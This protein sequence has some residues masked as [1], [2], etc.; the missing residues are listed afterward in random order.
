MTTWK[1]LIYSGSSAELLHVTASQILSEHLHL[2]TPDNLTT[3]FLGLKIH[4]NDT[5]ATKTAGMSFVISTNSY[6]ENARIHAQRLHGVASGELVF[7]TRVNQFNSIIE[8]MRINASGSVGIG[9]N[10]PSEL[11]TVAGNVSASGNLQIDGTSTF[12]NDVTLVSSSVNI[13]TFDEGILFYNGSNYTSNRIKLTTAQNLQYLAGGAHQFNAQSVQ[14]LS[15]T[16]LILENVDNTD[17]IRLRNNVGSGIGKARLDFTD[18]SN[19]VKMSISSS[20]KVGIGTTSPGN[21][22]HVFSGSMQVENGITGHLYLH[23]SNNYVYGDVNGVGI[24][25]AND[26]LRLSTAGNERIRVD[27]MGK[28]GIG[29]ST[30]TATLEVNGNIKATSFTGSL[31]GTASHAVSS[32]TASYALNAGDSIWHDSTTFISSSVDV[33]ISGSLNV[34]GDTN[35]GGDLGIGGSIFS[36]TGFGI[37]IDDVAVTSGSVNFGSGSI[38]SETNHSFT[39]SVSITGS[40]LILNDGHLNVRGTST[41]GWSNLSNARI[42]AGTSGQGI[43]IDTN[44]IAQ[45]GDH[46][47]IGTISSK[48]LVFRTNGANTRLTIKADGKVGIGTDSPNQKFEVKSGNIN[49]QNGDGGFLSFNNGDAN[50]KIHYND[51]QDGDTLITGRDLAFETFKTG[52]GTTEK[53]R[54]T[55]DGDVG[56]GT[57]TPTEKLHVD[58]NVRV[59]STQGYY[60]SFLQAIS[61]T[62]L[63]I[64]NDDYS[65]Y[66]FFKDDGNVGIGTDTPTAQLHV[67]GTSN[68]T[69]HIESHTQDA[70]VGILLDSL[71]AGSNTMGASHLYKQDFN[72]YLDS[73]ES[74]YIRP[75]N[76]TGFVITGN[77]DIQFISSSDNDAVQT[78]YFHA[79]SLT[80]RI[81]I[82]TASPTKA[83]TVEGDISASGNINIEGILSIPNFSDVSASLASVINATVD[84]AATATTA[85]SASFIS[86]NELNT[87]DSDK[88]YQITMIDDSTNDYEQLYVHSLL[89]WNPSSSTLIVRNADTSKETTLEIRG[90]SDNGSGKLFIGESTNNGGGIIYQGD[91]IPTRIINSPGIDYIGLYRKTSGIDRFVAGYKHDSSDFYFTGSVGIGTTSPDAKLHIAD[92]KQII[93]TG[94]NAAPQSQDYLFIGGDGLA[95]ANAAIYIGN[96]GDGTGYGWR[97][98]YEGVGSGNDNK[99]KIQ[100]ENEGAPVDAMTFLQDGNV[101]IG[102]DTPDKLLTV[103]GDI[104]ASATIYGQE[105]TIEPGSAHS[106]YDKLANFHGGRLVIAKKSNAVFLQPAAGGNEFEIT[107]AANN[108]GVKGNVLLRV[109]GDDSFDGTL[110]LAVDAS[111]KVGIGTSLP[112]E[113][114]DILGNLAIR[115]RKVLD[116][117]NANITR[118]PFNPIVAAI[119]NSGKCLRLDT[120]FTDDVNGV[121]VYNNAGGDVVTVNRIQ[122]SATEADPLFG[123]GNGTGSS[124]IDSLGVPNSSGYVIKVRYD[125]TGNANTVSPNLGGIVQYYNPD[126][127]YA[128]ELNHTYVQVFKAL[129]PVG[130]KLVPNENPQGEDKSTYFLTDHTGTG[131]WEW[132]ARVN[133]VGSYEN[134]YL[135][136]PDRVVGSAGHLSIVPTTGIAYGTA[137][138]WY[139]ASCTVYDVTEADA[140]THRRIG[141]GTREPQSELEVIGNISASATIQGA[142]ISASNLH[143]DENMTLDGDLGIGGTIFGLTGFGVTIDDIAITDGSTDFGSGSNPAV[144]IHSRTGSMSITGSTFTFNGEDVL[145]SGDHQWFE[146]NTELTSSKSVG[147]TGSLQVHGDVITQALKIRPSFPSDVIGID[148][149]HSQSIAD[150]GEFNFFPHLEF[151]GGNA[152]IGRTD[153]RNGGTP[154]QGIE[155]QNPAGGGQLILGNIASTNTNN[156]TIGNELDSGNASRRIS[157]RSPEHVFNDNNGNLGLT[158][159]ESIVYI[160]NGKITGSLSGDVYGTG[161]W[162]E[163]AITAAFATSASYATFAENVKPAFPFIGNAVI[164]G[165]LIMYN[166][167][168]P[169]NDLTD[170]ADIGPFLV[171]T[172]TPTNAFR[173]FNGIDFDGGG[174]DGEFTVWSS[175]ESDNSPEFTYNL[176]NKLGYSPIVNKFN[177]LFFASAYNHKSVEIYGTDDTGSGIGDLLYREPEVNGADLSRTRTFDNITPYKYITMRLRDGFQGSSGIALREVEYFG[178][179]Y[180]QSELLLGTASFADNA[181]SSSYA[182][183]VM[184]A[185]Y[186]ISSSHAVTAKNATSA[187]YAVSSSHTEYA[188]TASYAINIAQGQW[189]EVS[190]LDGDNIFLAE[191]T[192]SVDVG[193]SGS[194]NVTGDITAS[195][196]TIRPSDEIIIDFSYSQSVVDDFFGFAPILKFA[197]G[198]AYIGRGDHPLGVFGPRLEFQNASSDYQ[199]NLGSNQNYIIIQDDHSTVNPSIRLQSSKHVFTQK[200]ENGTSVNIATFSGSIAEFDVPIVSNQRIETTEITSSGPIHITGGSDVAMNQGK[201]FLILGDTTAA[202]IAIDNNEI[203][204]R[205]FSNGSVIANKLHL[206]TDGGSVNIGHNTDANVNMSGSLHLHGNLFASVSVGNNSVASQT[207]MYD[208]SS[209]QFY[210]TG[211]YGGGEAGA[212]SYTDLT[213]IPSDIVSSSAQ[214]T[215]MDAFTIPNHITHLG[216]PNTK[217]GFPGDDTFEVETAGNVSLH[218]ASDGDLHIRR[219]IVAFSTTPSDKRLKTDIQLLTGSL[220]TICNLEGVR[221]NW[222]Y[223]EDTPQLGVIAQQVEQHIPEIVKEMELPLHAPDGVK[224]KTVKYEQLVP[225]LIESIKQLRDELEQVK[226]QLKE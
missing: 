154:V 176:H 24:F 216:D 182:E 149:A 156:I 51:V 180:I 148:F 114:L 189:H 166:N 220:D 42:L 107:D 31:Q 49:I 171:A 206:Q 126:S 205:T 145:T 101:G 64:G 33:G 5:S 125:G 63:K 102:T 143:I 61:S 74:F 35:I 71:R 21:K 179:G 202:N 19:N 56:I 67:S 87:N 26:N 196:L 83:L 187:S 117:Q 212:S 46:L 39:G 127:P 210:F 138:N 120:D 153:I 1:K 32:V 8:R 151:A 90:S 130:Y 2:R 222:K 203:S 82:G 54:I 78:S 28:V 69:V 55:K 36:L 112:K 192:S 10:L 115:N 116:L 41:I 17:S 167:I 110:Q 62:G 119:R 163:N 135:T 14:I 165:S 47:Y 4:N 70:K 121:G 217:F 223:H 59:N 159:T 204:A 175:D 178:R 100:S 53:M 13:E 104:S 174:N 80:R 136:D 65:G 66:M 140:F 214:L 50:I 60:G 3:D 76:R 164:T 144:S 186:A 161:S 96:R 129:I 169:I 15:G 118:G 68:Q 40:E 224:Y 93:S 213:N 103:E 16:P 48:D 94:A 106:T 139:L 98:L 200:F 109:S 128:N 7:S 132:Y 208:T 181:T 195:T 91:D 99:L 218:V 97:F 9:T 29:T 155:L 57:T 162:S 157:Y 134:K 18:E 190:Q 152:R 124:D 146:T 20:G 30:P 123:L 147:I 25:N 141:V 197:G 89:S 34:T 131:K 185:S 133:H 38:P 12:N 170:A 105:L 137:V 193:I 225:H 122:W 177:V 194:L 75:N 191:L 27:S 219:D 6:Y 215:A 221:Y 77:S 88:D 45:K 37:T 85:I 160:T 72:T 158:I 58:G 108:N 142:I 207:V 183:N 172:Q 199:L 23:N 113:K 11:L 168:L 211:S 188:V 201:G 84:N 173:L 95:S 209:G 52:I 184:S 198:N 22:L 111:T 81:G 79:D 92:G 86:I 44:E 226:R 43:G 73:D 150:G